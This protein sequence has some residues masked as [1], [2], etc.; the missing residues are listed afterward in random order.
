MKYYSI[1]ATVALTLFI[2][3]YL[4]EDTGIDEIMRENA[5]LRHE[6]ALLEAR[7]DSAQSEINDKMEI[8]TYLRDR[9]ISF[10]DQKKSIHVHHQDNRNRISTASDSELIRIIAGQHKQV[11]SGY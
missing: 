1:I 6:K 4:S 10:E 2:F 9:M 11:P 7:M 8:I 3:L 5:S